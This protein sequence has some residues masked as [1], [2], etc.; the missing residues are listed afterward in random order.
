[1]LKV[2]ANL[3][4][5]VAQNRDASVEKGQLIEKYFTFRMDDSDDRFPNESFEFDL[6]KFLDKLPQ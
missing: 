2:N 1:M 5:V 6:P 4:A 3:D